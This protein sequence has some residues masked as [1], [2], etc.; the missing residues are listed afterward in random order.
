M[1]AAAP[2]YELTTQLDGTSYNVREN[3]A[4]ILRREL[5]GPVGPD[6][7]TIRV[8]PDTA[9]LIGRIAPHKVRLSAEGSTASAAAEGASAG[10]SDD[11][12]EDAALDPIADLEASDDGGAPDEDGGEDAP[13]KRGLMIPASMGLRFQ[14]P[15]EQ[16]SVRVTARWGTYQPVDTG[17]VSARGLPI[18]GY[19]R[20]QHERPI[21]VPVASLAQG[22]THEF[23]VHDKVLL[24]VDCHLDAHDEQRRLVEVALCNTAEVVDKIPT[25]VWL[26][27]T[28]L[29]VTAEGAAVFLPVADALATPPHPDDEDELKRLALQ[30]RDRLEF[31]L[32]RTCSVTWDAAPGARAATRVTTTWLPVSETPKTEAASNAAVITD[33]RALATASGDELRA[34]LRPLVTSYRTWLDA[35]DAIAAGLPDHLRTIADEAIFEARQV[36]T[37]LADGIEFVAADDEARRCF[38]FAN[39]V[40]ADQRVRSQVAAKRAADPSLSIKD[41]EASVAADGPKAHSWRLFQLAFVLLQLPALTDPAADRRSNP[42]LAAVE[43]LFFPTGG[44]KTEAYLGLAAYAFAIRRRQ[45]VVQSAS[46]PLDG[47]LGL[48]VLM[49]YT[50]RL[51]TAQQFQRATTMVCAAELERRRDPAVWGDEPFRI[52]LWVG[53]KVSP[54]RVDEAIKAIEKAKQDPR[55]DSD[56]SVLQVK[57][58]PW[59]GSPLSAAEVD[60]V[61]TTRR[62]HVWCSRD[63]ADCPFA[64]GGQVR[65]GLPVLTVD[66][67]IYRLAPAFVIATVDKF[68]RL[69]REGEAASLFGYVS[70]RCDRHGFVHPD[71]R[72]CTVDK[73]NTAGQFPP[74]WRRPHARL[75][76]PD[77]IIQDE[78]H[79]ITGALGTTVGLFETAIDT[80]C[81]WETPD[82][83]PVEPLIVASSATVRR[84]TSQIGR[85]YGRGAAIFPPQ[86]VDVADTYFSREKAPSKD[87]PGRRYLGVCASGVR[88]TMAEIRLAEVLMMAA[89]LLLDRDGKSADP[90]MTLVAYF[91]A[92]RELAGMKRFMGDDVQTTLEL[93]RRWSKL[94][95]RKPSIGS[96]LVVGELTARVP[97]TKITQ[98]LDQMGVPFDPDTYSTAARRARA[99]AFREAKLTGAEVA[100][101]GPVP[102]DAVLATS[103]LQV[104]VDVNRLGLM[105][106]VGQPKNTAEYIQASSRVGRADEAPG[107][108]VSLGNWARPRDLAH[109]ESFQHYHETFYSQVEALSVTPF[110][111]TSVDRGI[112][113]VLVSAARVLGAAAGENGL[114]PERG[115]SQVDAQ[116]AALASLVNAL[117]NRAERAGGQNAADLLRSRLNNRLDRWSARRKKLL[118][119]SRVLVYER[120]KPGSNEAALMIG[121]ETG[122]V[123]DDN[124]PPFVAANSMREVQ[125][126][127]NL[128]VSPKESRLMV[129]TADAPGWLFPAPKEDR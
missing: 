34:G 82:G 49:R 18:R 109:F 108:V 76:P 125:P 77:L 95:R 22:I 79:L 128:L 39:T 31:A 30:Y 65:D 48:T 15:V 19:R 80:L 94:P 74:A 42:D 67:E 93:G 62:V 72:E 13:Q 2:E 100:D 47:R 25:H 81:S 121:A 78:L 32:G 107:L 98:T 35:Q 111:E 11:E 124:T 68:A 53:S 20:T 23:T 66:E 113:G 54:K 59:C 88:M 129:T 60:A 119:S 58:C 10:L 9:Y 55:A 17:E 122:L 69:A 5:L 4:D 27:Q 120:A 127:I 112:D 117:V 37:R 75:R 116:A 41:A 71:Y 101:L 92:T 70:K 118:E 91:N 6:D 63:A 85:L 38:A 33:M 104:G 21:D 99:A 14:V 46:G 105:L 45:G 40:M 87:S 16:Q 96:D 50:L 24:K 43:L 29:D 61:V 26:F 1:T 90:Y 51:L 110:S 103:M 102:F 115:A 84:A 7:E 73:H 83:R 97:S 8:A 86:V 114:S 64:R 44:G 106:V 57:R 12:S 89:Q 36:A 3:L 123:P 56:L 52:G 126:E 28:E